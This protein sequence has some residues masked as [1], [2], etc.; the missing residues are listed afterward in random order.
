MKPSFNQQMLS[1]HLL[2]K[3]FIV[4]QPVALDYSQ[5]LQLKHSTATPLIT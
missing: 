5:G 2:L 1:Q 4:E 3:Y